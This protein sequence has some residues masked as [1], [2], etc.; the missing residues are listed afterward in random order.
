MATYRE[1]LK[2]TKASIREVDTAGAEARLG[3]AVFVDVRE[4]D[5][6]SQGTIPGSVHIPRGNLESNIEGR[7]TDHDAEVVVYCAGGMRSAF[8][9]KTLEDLGYSNVV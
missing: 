7:V 2:Q 9:A 1:L 3:Q 5:E 6:Y 8:A 4:P